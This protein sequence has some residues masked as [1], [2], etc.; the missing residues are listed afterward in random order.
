MQPSVDSAGG[1]SDALSTRGRSTACR[2]NSRN[3]K[4]RETPLQ[5]LAAAV[6][7]ALGL[8]SCVLP[9]TH[10]SPFPAR[11]T[12]LV[13]PCN[14]NSDRCFVGNKHKHQMTVGMHSFDA[15]CPDGRDQRHLLVTC[16]VGAL[17]CSHL[18]AARV[19]LCEM[20]NLLLPSPTPSC[21]VCFKYYH[22]R[23]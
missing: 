23:R 6:Q 18:E 2:F 9:Q 20:V 14:V 21:L 4:C 12:T 22:M 13:E 16:P 11:N 8:P 17:R 10:P 5:L 19:C 1:R 7:D 15:D 3:T